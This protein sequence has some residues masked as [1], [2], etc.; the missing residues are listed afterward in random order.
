MTDAVAKNDSG[1]S[2]PKSR[3]HASRS[4]PPGAGQRFLTTLGTTDIVGSTD[5]IARI[6]GAPWRDLPRPPL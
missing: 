1:R 3:M 2:R 5:L 6:G 4:P